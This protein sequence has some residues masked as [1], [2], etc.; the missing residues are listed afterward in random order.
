[1]VLRRLKKI[2][3]NEINNKFLGTTLELS[4]P[5]FDKLQVSHP[6]FPTAQ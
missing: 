1:M 3:N 4:L 5:V 2:N 6:L